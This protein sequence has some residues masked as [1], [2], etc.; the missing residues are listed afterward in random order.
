LRITENELLEEIS[1]IVRKGETGT[2]RESGKK[3]YNSFNLPKL[4]NAYMTKSRK[5]S[6]RNVAEM[7]EM[8]TQTLKNILQGGPL[9]DSMLFRIR[10]AL[11]YALEHPGVTVMGTEEDSY[12]G[13]WKKT[14][15]VKVQ[16][17]ISVVTEK[18]IFL[19]R[20]I[21]T[22]NSLKQD[23]APIDKIQI[24]QL[25]ALLE[26][27]LAALKAP[28]LEKK[29]TRGFF[30]WLTKL[31]KHGVEKGLERPVSDAIDSLVHAGTDLLTS[32]PD[33]TG[34]QDL[35]NIIV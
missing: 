18:L 19:K 28:Y 35:G 10:N 20:I 16:R 29:Q 34:P 2:S 26:A 12:P 24:A 17:A 14:N 21:E 27:M 1:K 8:S 25:I 3:F 23:N 32:L 5:T 30:K 9:S 4:L 6:L 31:G 15:T 22:S 7:F 13:D 11:E 33:S